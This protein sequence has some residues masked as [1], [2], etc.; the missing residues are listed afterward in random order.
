MFFARRAASSKLH[1]QSNTDKFDEEGYEDVN[2][3]VRFNGEEVR[4]SMENYKFHQAVRASI[5]GFAFL[6]GVVGMW[7]DGR[8]VAA[9]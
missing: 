3:S 4:K 2:G 5:S 9:P 7:G 1:E 8:P 6:L